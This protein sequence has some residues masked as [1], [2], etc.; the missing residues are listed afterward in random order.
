M[1][2]STLRF[3]GIAAIAAANCILAGCAAPFSAS[4]SGFSRPDAQLYKRFFLLPSES[5]L[6]VND[7]QFQEAARYVS[8]AL[9][10]KGYREVSNLSEC[11]LVV[12][13]QYGIGSPQT[14]TQNY[15]VPIIGQ[16][17]GGTSF[18]TATSYGRLGP[19]TITGTVTQPVTYGVTGYQAGSISQTLYG[20]WLRLDAIDYAEF[21]RSKNVKSVWETRIVSVGSSGDLRRVIPVMVAAAGS[22]LAENTMQSIEVTIRED[23]ER[24]Q[25]LMR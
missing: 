5:G 18:V 12:F 15:S 10:S 24:I 21:V 11:D 9:A 20:R 23:D 7:L 25:R 16:T 1:N 8:N 3:M 13:I 6:T 22:Y 14:F 17:G 2:F 19:Q 4:I